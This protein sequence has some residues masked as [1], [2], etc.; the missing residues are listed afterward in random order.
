MI[1]KMSSGLSE[2]S[3][4]KFARQVQ[5]TIGLQGEVNILLA[6]N[7]ELRVLNSRFRG[8]QRP[9]DVLSF[10]A[11]S[12]NGF[13]GNLAISVDYAVANASK[14]GHTA[15]EEIKILILHGFLHLAGYDHERDHGEMAAREGELRAQLRLP[16]SLIERNNPPKLRPA[17]GQKRR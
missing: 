12:R 9:T 5:R 8:I 7:D 13:A 14:L 6:G 1:R 10:P 4:A 11:A 3:L 17:K 2:A 16:E 15:V